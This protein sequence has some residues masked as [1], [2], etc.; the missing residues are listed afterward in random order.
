M[1]GDSCILTKEPGGKKIKRKLFGCLGIILFFSLGLAILGYIFWHQPIA[2]PDFLA[3]RLKNHIASRFGIE[4]TFSDSEITGQPGRVEIASLSL[5]LPGEN[6][7][8]FGKKVFIDMGKAESLWAAFKGQTPIELISGE[9]LVIDLTAP[10]PK[11]TGETKE[12]TVPGLKRMIND[13]CIVKFWGWEATVSNICFD[14]D[15]KKKT[16]SFQFR[17]LKNPLGGE[18]VSS[19]TIIFG[20]GQSQIYLDWKRLDLAKIHQMFFLGFIYGIPDLSGKVDLSL[21][22][23]GNL[24]DRIKSPLA[25]L[26]DLVQKEISGKIHFSD[27]KTLLRTIPVELEGT[28]TKSGETD[29]GLDVEARIASGT[30]HGNSKGSLEYGTLEKALFSIEG[31]DI[32]LDE[33]VLTSLEIPNSTLSLERFD[34]FSQGIVRKNTL[35]TWSGTVTFQNVRFQ[36]ILSRKIEL[37][38]ASSFGQLVASL[39]AD[40]FEGSIH[41]VASTPFPLTGNPKIDIRGNIVH[42]QGKPAS[43][44]LVN[45]PFDGV[46][47]GEFGLSLCGF[48]YLGAEYKGKL[49][50]QNPTVASISAKEF[51]SE[52]QGKGVAWE[53]KDPH[54]E[55]SEGG[56]IK[57]NGI[58]SPEDSQGEFFIR[59]FPSHVG[60]LA[61]QMA[62]GKISCDGSVSG[63]FPNLKLEG[64]AWSRSF[65]IGSQEFAPLKTR[66]AIKG[67]TLNITS[68]F[69]K[70]REGGEVDGHALIHLSTGA[71]GDM[72]LN[73]SRVDLSLLK[74]CTSALFGTYPVSGLVN[75]S[76]G[77]KSAGAQAPF[78]FHFSGKNIIIASE[79][80]KSFSLEGNATRDRIEIR[81]MPLRVFGGTLD[82][83][84]NYEPLAGFLG[85]FEAKDFNLAKIQ[86]TNN[87]LTKISGSLSLNGKIDWTKEK[88][89]GS[90]EI[91]GKKWILN[92]VNLG[93]FIGQLRMNPDGMQ[94]IQANFDKIGITGSGTLGFRDKKPFE[95]TIHLSEADLSIIPG[96]LNLAGFR[97]G[98]VVV[99]GLLHMRGESISAP[100]D[101]AFC[102]IEKMEI[103]Q[104][105]EV[106]LSKKPIQIRYQKETFD[107]QSFSLGLGKAILGMTGTYKLFG[108]SDIRFSGKDV[109]LSS[110]GTFLNKPD[111]GI[112]GYV[113]AEGS[114]AGVYP[115]LSLHGDLKVETLSF[116][117]KVIPEISAKVH[118]NRDGGKVEPLMVSL[119]KNKIILNGFFPFHNGENPQ[120]LDVTINIASG[121]LD[122]LLYYP[123]VF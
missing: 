20:P 6:P 38:W 103:H 14:V 107:I 4:L 89:E 13:F 110:L 88:K 33:R 59:D 106:I 47:N 83:S 49:K 62:D 28:L 21:S 22:W 54:V 73:L 112:D 8:F 19:G 70:I 58:L 41:L 114:I 108:P 42:V 48:D 94:V 45:K 17:L 9:G 37:V 71:V 115:N 52:I 78:D 100:P 39:A 84:G 34:F 102:S 105:K 68:L 123:T 66:L 5:S 16:G 15:H 116:D 10:F 92:D 24:E 32:H 60:G 26:K 79:T 69:G 18:G 1:I 111:G 2:I 46:I 7:F 99:D 86:S 119:P 40:L 25:N 122:A 87:A 96:Y 36:E 101:E 98:D 64:N 85:T 3:S 90:V 12:L 61:P 30:I 51:S 27:V 97:K 104:G 65:A 67:D 81:K 72:Q 120:K 95:A 43:I 80:V 121:P 57:F 74:K 76:I 93:D 11:S 31:T 82:L 118:M 75:G 117:G 113:S 55:F 109:S 44:I 35:E 91:K 63:K 56:F 77:K 50:I 23:K 29:L 53:L